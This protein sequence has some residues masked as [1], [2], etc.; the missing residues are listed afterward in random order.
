[1]R[2]HS[3]WQVYFLQLLV[4]F[5]VSGSATKPISIL[6][7]SSASVDY[8]ECGY[9]LDKKLILLNINIVCK[10]FGVY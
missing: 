7:I 10:K 4:A 8:C 1:M 6:A 3:V 2:M 5:L 9:Y